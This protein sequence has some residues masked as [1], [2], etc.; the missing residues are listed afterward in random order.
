MFLK[1][2]IK[3]IINKYEVELESKEMISCSLFSQIFES[4]EFRKVIAIEKYT[5]FYFELIDE[6]DIY[7]VI[8]Y[9]KNDDSLFPTAKTES[10]DEYIKEGFQKYYVELYE[11]IILLN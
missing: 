1:S 7:V 4:F 9:N 8:T 10:L 3:Y 6:K 11:E 5:R 2:F